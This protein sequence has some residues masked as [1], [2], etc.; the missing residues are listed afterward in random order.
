MDLRMTVVTRRDAVSCAGRQDLLHFQLTVRPAFLDKARLQRS[1]ATAAAVVVRP[2]GIH[3]D[4]ILFAYHF[5]QN[6]PHVFGNRVAVGFSHGL[7]RVVKREFEFKI[8]VPFGADLQIAFTDPFGIVVKDTV[9]LKIVRDF[10]ALQSG[11]DCEEFVPSL[12]VEPYLAVQVVDRLGLGADDAL[13]I[14]F[15]RDE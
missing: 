1:P 3:L 4:E 6:I 9:D 12:R 11:P 15:V 13:P 10:E 7:T 5:F 2:V 14:L 8:L